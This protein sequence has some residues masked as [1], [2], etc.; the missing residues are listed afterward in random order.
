M[1]G[2]LFQPDRAL[3]ILCSCNSKQSVSIELVDDLA[4]IDHN[5]KIIVRE[6]TKNTIQTNTQTFKNRS[7]D[8][9]NT[10]DI[11]CQAVKD[12]ALD[13]ENT[14]LVCVTNAEL[15]DNLIIK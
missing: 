6:Q 2:Y 10:L 3:V 4:I 14:K 11:W 1:A 8:L 15:E 12:A 5:G 13:I 7:K 9:W